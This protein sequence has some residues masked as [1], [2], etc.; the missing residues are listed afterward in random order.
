[1]SISFN[2]P[3]CNT[4]LTIASKYAGKKGRCSKCQNKFLI[5]TINASNSLL[6]E[7]DVNA[8]VRPVQRT[9]SGLIIPR[10][11]APLVIKPGNVDT[12][13]LNT[14]GEADRSFEGH[15]NIIQRIRSIPPIIML[16]I[17][18]APPA[19]IAQ[20]LLISGFVRNLTHNPLDGNIG[21][22]HESM[23]EWKKD[24]CSNVFTRVDD[25][26]VKY[27]SR[28]LVQKASDIRHFFPSDAFMASDGIDGRL[29]LYYSKALAERFPK[30]K[31]VGK[32]HIS[33]SGRRID[34]YE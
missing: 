6:E 30:K 25:D 7:S 8:A 4:S 23:P 16:C 28:I 32:F 34:T 1:M 9:D 3:H 15:K 5:P 29:K 27:V 2:C 18:L 24:L 11:I 19:A 17:V 10:R 22:T 14:A 31:S 13:S 33:S 26:G 12:L 20:T 21:G